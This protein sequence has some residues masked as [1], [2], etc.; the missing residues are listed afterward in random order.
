MSANEKG[1][2]KEVGD[3]KEC[4]G[5]TTREGLGVTQLDG[6][7]L[8]VAI[9][10]HRRGQHTKKHF[11]SYS[12][13]FSYTTSCEDVLISDFLSDSPITRGLTTHA[14]TVDDSPICS[15]QKIRNQ[16]YL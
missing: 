7:T 1:I 8:G 16:F 3:I 12:R 9:C 4:S 14:A 2:E 10:K 15:T 6:V 13:K 5:R 11:K